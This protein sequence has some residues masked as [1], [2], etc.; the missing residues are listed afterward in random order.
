M[1]RRT[2]PML[3]LLAGVCFGES[4]EADWWRRQVHDL[5]SPAD[6]E[7]H[8]KAIHMEADQSIVIDSPSVAFRDPETGQPALLTAD[9][10]T[11]W[12]DGPLDPAKP[13]AMKAIRMDKP[14]LNLALDPRPTTQPATRPTT[15]PD[16]T[17][18][19]TLLNTLR[20]VEI[21]RGQLII[22]TTEGKPAEVKSITLSAEQNEKQEW[23][24]K[25]QT[26]LL[27]MFPDAI[28]N[29]T[30]K[31]NLRD[32]TAKVDISLKADPL[33]LK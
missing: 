12:P 13:L 28:Y 8:Y 20:K 11:L 23:V 25:A 26:D 1:F 3:L 10:I 7:V 27:P 29:F 17:T 4:R 31:L 24:G 32:D 6:V 21:D 22:K 9:R 30:A 2:I 18:I 5:F 16:L 19:E 14:V 33:K 15:Q